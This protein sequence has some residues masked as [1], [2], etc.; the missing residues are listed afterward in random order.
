MAAG[1]CVAAVDAV[2]KGK[3]HTALCLIRP[4]G[5]HATRTRSM[6]FCLFNNIALAA[7]HC[8][9]RS[10]SGSSPDRRLGRSS[11]QWDPGHFL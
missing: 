2:L 4:P 7:Q 10:Q 11:R 9:S 5:H 6:G 8:A 3:E 1:T